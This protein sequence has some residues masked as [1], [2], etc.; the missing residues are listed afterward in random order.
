MDALFDISF[1]ACTV[2]TWHTYQASVRQQ[3]WSSTI[4]HLE[5]SA[6]RRRHRHPRDEPRYPGAV[7]DIQGRTAQRRQ[8]GDGGVRGR[9]VRQLLR[10]A[11]EAAVRVLA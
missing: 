9:Q 11:A 1:G 8:G 4:A 2:A 5:A 10:P 3:Q 6:A 7:N